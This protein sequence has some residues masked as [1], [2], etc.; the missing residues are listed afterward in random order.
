MC[1]KVKAYRADYEFNG[2]ATFL[3]M[4]KDTVTMWGA[5]I[6][7]AAG[8]FHLWKGWA[9]RRDSFVIGLHALSPKFENRKYLHVKN[10]S[11]HNIRIL[12][13]GFIVQDGRRLSIPGEFEGAAG[14]NVQGF[15]LLNEIKPHEHQEACLNYRVTVL[16]AYAISTTSRWVHFAFNDH[17]PLS[18]R[19][20]LSAYVWLFGYDSLW[21]L[22]FS[23]YTFRRDPM[24][25]DL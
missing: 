13:Y 4:Y 3:Q 25:K 5:V 15:E 14:T 24:F 6:A 18:F 12:D 7:A 21:K 20:K 8:L 17:V 23:D 22:K 19:I 16:A 11:Q 1:S 2:G 10:T 9:D